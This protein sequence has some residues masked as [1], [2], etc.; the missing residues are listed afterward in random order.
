MLQHG[1]RINGIRKNLKRSGDR[2]RIQNKTEWVSGQCRS[3]YRI[4]LASDILGITP[5]NPQPLK[6]WEQIVKERDEKKSELA[7]TFELVP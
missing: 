1:A 6:S 3:W 5:A 4:I 7:P 2:E